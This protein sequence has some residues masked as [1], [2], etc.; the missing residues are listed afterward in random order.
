MNLF[1]LMENH[2][3]A[4]AGCFENTPVLHYLAEAEWRENRWKPA[5]CDYCKKSI[6]EIFLRKE[7]RLYE[8]TFILFLLA[9]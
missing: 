2:I 5:E 3:M 6:N 4:Q 7:E 1:S 9:L 8:K